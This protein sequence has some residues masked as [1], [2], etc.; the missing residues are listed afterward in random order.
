[1]KKLIKYLIIILSL[2][3]ITCLI[4]LLINNNKNKQE[5][6]SE[7]DSEAKP[8]ERYT[9]VKEKYDCNEFEFVNVTTES[10]ILTYFNKYKNNM[11]Q[12]VEKAYNTLDPEYRQKRFGSIEQ[13]KL[14]INENYEKL[15]ALSLSGYKLDNTNKDYNKYICV[16]QNGNY[17]IFKETAVMQYTLML[18]DYTIDSPEFIE[19]YNSTNEQGKVALNIDRFIKAINTSDYNYAYNCLSNG[20]KSNYFNNL[21][22]FKNYVKRTFYENNKV[23][24]KSYTEQSG[25]YKYTIEI[26]NEEQKKLEKTIIMKLNEGTGFEMSFDI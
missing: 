12:D 21:E 14:Y 16:D 19:K 2:I 3:I 1:M 17:Y 25:L 9:K 6:N 11:F 15:I 20:F 4:L 5:I 23:E 13:Y 8:E 7:I 22:I 26:T 24:Y 10:L 18:D